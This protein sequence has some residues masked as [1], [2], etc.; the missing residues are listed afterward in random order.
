MTCI[1]I[2]L[3]GTLID[4]V[5]DLAN[6]ANLMLA[7]MNKEPCDEQ[8]VLLGI[9]LQKDIDEVEHVGLRMVREPSTGLA[10]EHTQT[11]SLA[12]GHHL[13]ARE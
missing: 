11:F 10:S 6:A 9:E 2:D 7:R 12:E 5:P 1:A 3:D 13:A 4:S 8:D